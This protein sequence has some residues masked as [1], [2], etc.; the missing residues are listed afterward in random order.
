MQFKI[1][2]QLQFNLQ[3][4]H[5]QAT[6][7]ISCIRLCPTGQIFSTLMYHILAYRSIVSIAFTPQRT[8]VHIQNKYSNDT[9]PAGIQFSLCLNKKKSL[10]I[11][12][13]WQDTLCI[14]I[15][16]MYSGNDK[17]QKAKIVYQ[18]KWNLMISTSRI[19]HP[20]FEYNLSL[21]IIVFSQQTY[22]VCISI[23]L[24]NY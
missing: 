4:K 21:I 23:T 18:D 19:F 16:P 3:Y 17:K 13:F 5:I 7:T 1:I 15:S 2:C 9:K 12:N 20:L 22:D 14:I 24:F 10:C 8:C 6:Q 11:F